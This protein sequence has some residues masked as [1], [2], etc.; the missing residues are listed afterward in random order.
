[1]KYMML[2]ILLLIPACGVAGENNKKLKKEYRAE[3]KR[4]KE[5]ISRLEGH[6][7]KLEGRSQES[8]NSL[9]GLTVREW[10]ETHG[11]KADGPDYSETKPGKSKIYDFSLPYGPGKQYKDY[12]EWYDAVQPIIPAG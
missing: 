1:M 12:D 9:R 8:D 3:I 5:K 6:I 11:E 2:L 10:E 4:L 7:R